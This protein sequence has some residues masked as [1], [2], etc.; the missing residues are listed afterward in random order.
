MSLGAFAVVAARERELGVPV[1]LREHG[2]LR[3]GAAAARRS[4]CGRSCSAS[5]ASR[6]RA[7]SS[8]SSTSSLPPTGH[9]WTWLVI[10][11]VLATLVSLYYYLGL[12]R[13]MFMRR[14]EDLQLAP[15]GGSP[16][17]EALLQ[18]A[19]VVCL[20]VTVGTFFAVQPLI[21]LR[22]NA[23]DSCLSELR[24]TNL[25]CG[26]LGS[27]PAPSR[28]SGFV[29]LLAQPEWDVHWEDH[30]AHFW[31]VFSVALV[32]RAARPRHERSSRT[33]WRRAG[34]PHRTRV[35]GQCRVSRAARAGHSRRSARW[36]EHGLRDRNSSRPVS[37]LD[38]R[39]VVGPRVR[40]PTQSVAIMRRERLDP[41]R[42]S[43][44][45][46]RRGRSGRS[47]LCPRSTVHS[48]RNRRRPD[49]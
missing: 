21:D 26:S 11:G 5:R 32:M 20:V 19:V 41:G 44:C 27:R 48:R 2:R 40:R 4:R 3:L 14:T 45:S 8:A 9:G 12:V 30:R 34:V 46:W 47:L 6:S 33:A 49:R 13:A 17:R 22:E 29:L 28:R 36:N 15:I 24:L 18:T 25:A 38:P 16:P 37:R 7:A 31:L 23:A 35:P 43:C 10:V 42:A 39:R 1:T